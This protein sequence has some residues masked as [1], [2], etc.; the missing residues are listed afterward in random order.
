MPI[1]TSDIQQLRQHTGVGMMEA[2]RALEEA[3]GKMDVAVANLRKSGQKIAQKKSERQVKEG[4]VGT[5]LHSNKKVGTMV[6]LACETDF[7]ARTEEFM[8]LAHDL[9]LHVAATNPLY[10]QS[11]EVPAEIIAQEE[12]IY[13]AQLLS[14][15]KPEAMWE[16]IIPGKLQKYYSETCLLQQ[17]F[18]KDDSKTVQAVLQEAIARLGENIQIIS[19]SR[20]AV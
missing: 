14:E 3:Q 6:A 20:V 9:A 10:L 7:V 13:R 16:K 15:G 2:K 8:A 1:S 12:E 18:V 11:S 4:V 19:F 5:Y 17:L